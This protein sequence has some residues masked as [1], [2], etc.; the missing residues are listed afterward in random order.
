MYDYGR[1]RQLHIEKSLEATHLVTH[2][3]KVQPTELADRTV[4]IDVEYFRVERLVVTG[5]RLGK[6]LPSE[7][8]PQGLCYLFAAEGAGRVIGPDFD[9]VDLPARGIVA[10]PASAPSF[11]VID[12][13]GLDLIRIAPNWPTV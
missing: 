11:L 2:A 6:T 9:P 10:I 1:A 3:G 12:L 13:G 8:E 5:S 4:L 7:R